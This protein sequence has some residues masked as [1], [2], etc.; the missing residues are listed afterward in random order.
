MKILLSI[1]MFCMIIDPTFAITAKAPTE[2]LPPIDTDS[3]WAIVAIIRYL[4]LLGT[5][6]AVMAVTW[7]G[8][9]LMLATGDDEKMKKS[10][11]TIIF[12]F[13]WVMVSGLAYS[14]VDIITRAHLN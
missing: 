2:L 12:A 10:R 4:I 11:K 8:I 5:I 13:I 1:V 7:G 3:T 6:L 9:G 14:I